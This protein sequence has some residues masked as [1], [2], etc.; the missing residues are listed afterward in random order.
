MIYYYVKN[1]D[2]YLKDG[3]SQLP[4]LYS[5][6]NSDVQHFQFNK[7]FKPVYEIPQER[8]VVLLDLRHRLVAQ[9]LMHYTIPEETHEAIKNNRC[10]I[11]LFGWM[12]NW[13]DNEFQQI[14]ATLKRK[15]E[16]LEQ[17]Y[18]VYVSCSL[19][20]FH[21]KEYTHIYANKMEW[22]WHECNYKKVERNSKDKRFQP[23]FKFICLNRRPSWHRFLTVS[24]MFD[25][26]RDGMLTHLSP[27]SV[28]NDYQYGYKTAKRHYDDHYEVFRD[29]EVKSLPKYVEP[30]EALESDWTG[31]GHIEELGEEKFED[32]IIRRSKYVYETM[33]FAFDWIVT[34]DRSA[35]RKLHRLMWP[36]G[37]ASKEHDNWSLDFPKKINEF[38]NSYGFHSNYQEQD[39][40]HMVWYWKKESTG[41]IFRGRT[42]EEMMEVRNKHLTLP[43]PPKQKSE[44]VLAKR[45]KK[46][47]EQNLPLLIK[48][49]KHK[50]HN[51]D[52]PNKD[53][54]S[55]KY[56][57][58]MIHVVTETTAEHNQ[59]L[60][61]SEKTFKPMFYKRP[62]LIAG[63]KGLYKKLHTLGYKTFSN[64]FNENFDNTTNDWKRITEVCNEAVKWA[65]RTKEQC[66]DL[67][68]E[69]KDIC[70]SNFKNLV[71]RGKNAEKNLHDKILETF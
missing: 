54:D 44:G 42:R 55:V 1:R 66:S 67:F 28:Y 18:F 3:W 60:F 16:W 20:D 36:K 33:K 38:F 34:H 23:A 68:N 10:K 49:D 46:M 9:H 22:Q 69:T 32:L 21:N 15:H 11:L 29:M 14:F 40:H 41:E 2:N 65:K 26:R 25:H 51:G 71:E 5:E 24:H 64:I 27:D 35:H 63:Q 58:A 31:I 13:S 59:D 8:F 52:N 47:V 53:V 17:K 62:F 70:D 50:I 43:P 4:K 56:L 19:E 6:I 61:A 48:E 37:K 57:K 39:H 45:W 12:E 30:A 7:H